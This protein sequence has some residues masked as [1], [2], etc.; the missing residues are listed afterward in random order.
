MQF[1]IFA[2]WV[3]VGLFAG[4]LAGFVI[5]DGGYGLAGDLFLGLFG[6]MGGSLIFWALE[7]SPGAG[8]F[9]LAFVA[10]LGAAIVIVAQRKIWYA[11]A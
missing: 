10:F 8:L 4:W 6:S 2:M 11:P 5:K 3:L 9:A 7:V 1:G